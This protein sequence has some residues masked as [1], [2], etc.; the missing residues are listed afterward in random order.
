[1]A[2]MSPKATMSTS[3]R[4]DRNL[5]VRIP[6]EMS[7]KLADLS[8]REGEPIPTITRLLLKGAIERAARGEPVLRA[9]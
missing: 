1:M 6:A 5:L 9:G 8:R 7:G 2:T 4:Y 3:T